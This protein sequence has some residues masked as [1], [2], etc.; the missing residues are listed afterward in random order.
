ML[1]FRVCNVRGVWRWGTASVSSTHLTFL[2]ETSSFCRTPPTPDY[3][4][5]APLNYQG[6]QTIPWAGL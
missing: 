6:A 2:L 3:S 1:N 5:A 4:N